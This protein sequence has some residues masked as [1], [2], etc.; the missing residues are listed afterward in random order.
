MAE[1]LEVVK[2]HTGW[3]VLKPDIVGADNWF[4]AEAD[5]HKFAVVDGLIKAMEQ[6]IEG[7]CVFSLDPLTHAKNC[8]A[9]TREVASTALAAACVPA[10]A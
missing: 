2:T 6:I 9:F 8:I 5:A 7:R 1:K 10:G 4:G 3:N